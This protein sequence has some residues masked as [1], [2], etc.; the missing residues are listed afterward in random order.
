MTGKKVPDPS[1]PAGETACATDVWPP[2]IVAGPLSPAALTP[3]VADVVSHAVGAPEYLAERA[4]DALR[5][6]LRVVEAGGKPCPEKEDHRFADPAWGAPPFSFYASN[7]LLIEEW[8]TK[9]ILHT[10]GASEHHAKLAAFAARQWLDAFSPSNLPWANPEILRATLK[11]GG[12]NFLHGLENWL[13]DLRH[14]LDP[15]AAPASDDY[16][17]GR[18]VALT[19]G[20]VVLRNELI[21]LI[22][23]APHTPQTRP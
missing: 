21:E 6:S 23:Y 13:E 1:N 20:K 14:A 22:Q 15:K 18:D 12:A 11:E 9:A 8:L 10:P 4:E 19:P 5:Q 3:A 7:F 17:V 2:E 16:V